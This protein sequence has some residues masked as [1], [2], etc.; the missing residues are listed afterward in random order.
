L[1]QNVTRK[2]QENQEGLELNGIH[3]LLVYA[4]DVNKVG[5]N[6]NTTEKN[7]EALYAP[8]KEGALQVHAGKTRYMFK[9]CHKN[10]G[11]NHNLKGANVS[12][13]DLAKFKY[14][15]TTVTDQNCTRKEIKSRLNLGNACNHSVQYLL[16]PVSSK[17]SKT[18]T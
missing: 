8:S 3:Q 2:V 17:N 14:L 13:E 12:S 7:T 11:L 9:S 16:L 5:K 18:K 4:D 6:I 1:L 15:G 10:A